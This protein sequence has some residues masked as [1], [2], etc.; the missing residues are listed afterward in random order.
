[1]N[2][3]K[4]KVYIAC[5]NLRGEWA[6]LPDGFQRINVTSAQRKTSKYRL[7]FS[8]MTPIEGGY[9]NFY[10]FE[11]YWQSG[12]RYEGLEDIDKQL[13]W[14]KKQIKGRR[15]YPP[16]KDKKVM[17]AIFPD[18]KEPLLYIPSRKLVYV[19]EYYS[20]I[21]DLPLLAKLKKDIKNGK[22]LAIYDFDGPRMS[23]GKPTVKEITLDFIRDKINDPTFPFGHGYIVAA[24][25]A[26]IKMDKYL[27]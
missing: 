19:P 18:F 26:G 6:S 10:C 21:C 25:I 3:T 2:T 17:H 20:L 11:N 13:L 1:M 5:M 7:A 27:K 12:K 9:K 24:A 8:P 15:K 22:N 4:G 23:N 14:W 16:G